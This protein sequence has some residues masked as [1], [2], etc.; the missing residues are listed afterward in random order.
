MIIV[1]NY[2][3]SMRST[4]VAAG[5]VFRIAPGTQKTLECLPLLLTG[6]KGQ[7]AQTQLI[8]AI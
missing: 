8:V 6:L 4:W 1:S 3:L 2:K 5:E 7:L